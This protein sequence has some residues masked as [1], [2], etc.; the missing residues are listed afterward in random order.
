M[1]IV[2]RLDNKVFIE[3]EQKLPNIPK[4]WGYEQIIV[5]NDLYCL[6]QLIF[7]RAGSSFSMH[8]HATKDETW[9][10]SKGSFDLELIDLET[11]KRIFKH[12]PEHSIIRIKPGVPHKLTALEDSSVILEVST[13]DSSTDNYRV[14]P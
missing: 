13:K 1:L 2:N 8:F 10:V 9:V 4:K 3:E 14:A 12:L 5:S 7:D 11:T 6:K